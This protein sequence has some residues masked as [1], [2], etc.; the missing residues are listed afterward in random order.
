MRVFFLIF[1]ILSWNTTL[2]ASPPGSVKDLK[3]MV[4]PNGRYFIDQNGKPFFYLGD[5]AWLIFQRW[6]RDEVE[7]YLK[8]RAGKGFTVLQAYVLRGLDARHP[9][10][11]TSLVGATPLIERDPTRFNEPFFK[12]VDHVINRANV[13]VSL[14]DG[15]H[16]GSPFFDWLVTMRSTHG[17]L[18]RTSMTGFFMRNSPMPAVV[19]PARELLRDFRGLPN[20]KKIANRRSS[21]LANGGTDYSHSGTRRTSAANLR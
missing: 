15:Y 20:E 17:N 10:G 5:T 18:R 3:L 21:V 11:S 14:K 7:E 12:N 4:S 2:G 1:S 9:D 19:L 16:Y 8:D 13:L 6:T